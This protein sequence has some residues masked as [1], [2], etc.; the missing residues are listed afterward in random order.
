MSASGRGVW[1]RKNR[2]DE[3]R[4]IDILDLQRKKVFSSRLGMIWTCSW[5][6][7]G[8]V[9]ASISY[10]VEAGEDG[11]FALRFMYTMTDNDTGDKKSYNY[12]IP[13]VFTPCNYGGKRWWYVCPLIVDGRSCNRRCRIVYL[14][15]GSQYFGCR[16]CH[17]LTYES[18]QR[19]REKFYEGFEKPYKAAKAVREKFSRTRSWERREKLWR[20]LL[21]AQATFERFENILTSRTPK[22]IYKEK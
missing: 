17:R 4:S 9:V 22:I 6:R 21:R 10:R 14:P 3:V 15:H 19:H 1:N 20:K 12:V 13:V 18:R 7:N 16:E 2:V 11:P 5:S 8:E